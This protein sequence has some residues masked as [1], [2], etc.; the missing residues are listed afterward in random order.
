[1]IKTLS[2]FSAEFGRS[3]HADKDSDVLTEKREIHIPT[4]N[5]YMNYEIN[6]TT[7]LRDHYQNDIDHVVRKLHEVMVE[8]SGFTLSRIDQLHVQIFK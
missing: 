2:Y 6:T 1:M 3:F 5:W 7:D 4:V 8:G